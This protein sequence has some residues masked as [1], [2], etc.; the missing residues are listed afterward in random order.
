LF[1]AGAEAGADRVVEDVVERSGQIVV[2][3]DGARGVA[4]TE[5]VA[6]ALMA[7]VERQR[8]DPVEPMHPAG[9]RLD[10][11]L[12]HEVVVRRHQAVRVELPVETLDAV[13]EEN[14]EARPVEPVAEDRP[15]VHAERRDVEDAVR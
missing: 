8:V 3:G 1:G 15:L 4:V 2:V 12:E 9:H 14:E 13:P 10:G 5:E 7:T 11:G 6:P